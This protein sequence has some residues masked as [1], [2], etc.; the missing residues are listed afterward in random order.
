M[1]YVSVFLVPLY[2]APSLFQK[3]QF[4][5]SYRQIA[6]M[7]TLLSVI[8]HDV[9]DDKTVTSNSKGVTRFEIQH[10]YQVSPYALGISMRQMSA[11]LYAIISINLTIFYIFL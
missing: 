10:I 1:C 7:G 4:E 5:T 9:L 11:T 6:R 3:N 2:I 8:E